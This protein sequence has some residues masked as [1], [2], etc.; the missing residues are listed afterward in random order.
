[1]SEMYVS[2][3]CR[4]QLFHMKIAFHISKNN[5]YAPELQIVKNALKSQTDALVDIICFCWHLINSL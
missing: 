5:P 1:M 3:D 2:I 4:E